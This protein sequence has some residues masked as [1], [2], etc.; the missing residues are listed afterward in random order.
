MGKG[1]A[2][3][4]NSLHKGQNNFVINIDFMGINRH[5]KF[6]KQTFLQKQM[7]QIQGFQINSP[8]LQLSY[9]C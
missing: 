2:Y 5:R 7:H 3:L 6:Q 1:H 4:G 8:F 9:F